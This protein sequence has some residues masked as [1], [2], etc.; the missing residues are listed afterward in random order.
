MAYVGGGFGKGIHNILEAAVYGIPVMFGPKNQKFNEA[1]ALKKRGGGFEVRDA[2]D[3]IQNINR[4]LGDEEGRKKEGLHAY[5]Y[6]QEN[7]G[8]S[9][10]ILRKI[11]KRLH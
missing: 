1:A 9:Q 3:I 2:E 7:A 4:W 11:E 10:K 5:G 8:A 6:L